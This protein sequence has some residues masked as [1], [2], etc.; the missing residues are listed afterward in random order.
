MLPVSQPATA[1][2][3][4]QKRCRSGP[5]SFPRVYVFYEADIQHAGFRRPIVRQLH[6]GGKANVW[7]NDWRL[8]RLPQLD[9]AAPDRVT[10][11]SSTAVAAVLDG[12]SRREAGEWLTPDGSSGRMKR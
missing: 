1:P 7:D 6:A 8:L 2:M 10:S 4:N 3:T 12:G 11:F 5:W 9:E